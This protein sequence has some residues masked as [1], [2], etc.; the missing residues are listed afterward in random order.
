MT[1]PTLQPPIPPSRS[2]ARR[3]VRADLGVGVLPLSALAGATWWLFGLPASYLM[4]V[5]ALYLA[6][7]GL[8][9]L[10]IA[11][12]ASTRGIGTANRITLGRATLVLPVALL[13]LHVEYV[14]E[15][16]Y[17]WIILWSAAAML[18]DSVDGRV[19]RRTGTTSNFGA[20]FDMELDAFLILVLSLLVL[21]SGKVGAWVL[22]IGGIRYLLVAAGWVWPALT[23]ELPESQ[24]RK[25]VCVVQGIVLLLCL[26]PITP[27]SAALVAT[28]GAFLLL[29]YSFVVD[30]AWLSR[31]GEVRGIH[32]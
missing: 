25:I 17:W 31:E 27:P 1:R 24:R 14:L 21:Q 20:R 2:A 19:A 15:S 10:G 5:G 3:S 28:A 16:G 18:L 6:M 4:Q 7:S 23:G 8:V 13:T 22:L 30:I 29:V 9:G 26:A 32:G 12:E 11:G